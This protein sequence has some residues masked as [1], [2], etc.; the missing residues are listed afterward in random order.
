MDFYKIRTREV[1][2]DVIEI[3]PSFLV[4]QSK[5]LMVRG[6]KFYAIWDAEK[7]LWST[8]ASDVCR[9]I[10]NELWDARHKIAEENPGKKIRISTMT[11][12]SSRLWTEFLKFVR[13]AVD[14][15]HQLD[16]SLTFLSSKTKKKDYSS[17]RLSY[18]LCSGDHS[19]YDEI[20]RTLYADE[21]R[22]KI[23]W[24]IGSIIAGDSKTIQKF[25]VL[26]GEPGVGKGT[27][28]N[29]IQLL[30]EGYYA[31]FD[32][33]ALTT[34]NDS[35]STEVLK[36]N[37]LVAIQHDGDL[38]KI[39]DNTK[40]NSIIAHEHTIINEKYKGKYSMNLNGFLFIGSNKPVKITESRSGIIRRLIDVHPANRPIEPKRYQMLM[41]QV[42]FELGAIA[43]HCLNV[44]REMGKN[45]YSNYKPFAM[46]YQTDP[47]FNFV[48]DSYDLF[49]ETP[50]ISLTRAYDMYKRYCEEAGLEF[51]M[52]RP[53]MREE[54]KTY[55]SAYHDR[56]R[57]DG[58]LVRH[59]FEGF[60]TNKFQIQKEDIE[61][62][63]ISLTLDYSVSLLDEAFSDCPAQYCTEDE[64]PLF[65]WCNVKTK[66][67][68]LDTRRTHYVLP[69]GIHICI[70]F[71]IR[72]EK[73]EK[74]PILNLEAASKWPSTYAEYSKSGGGI[75]LH[76]IYEGDVGKLSRL[77]QEGI[78]VK[79]FTG[80][81]S[82]RRKLS[83]CNNVPIA[84]LTG[85][86]PLKGEK[87]VNL[88]QIKSEKGLREMILRNLRK[89]I[90]QATKPSMDFIDKILNDAYVSGMKYDVSD[91][92][93]KILVFATG[94]TNQSDYCIKLIKNMK[95]KSEE[96]EV[97]APIEETTELV[98][99]DVEVFP[100][101]FIVN[102]KIDGEEKKVVRMINPTPS[103]IEELMKMKLVG[104]NCRRYDN[105]ILYGR[106]LGYNNLQL[107]QL[108]KR[109]IDGVPGSLFGEAYNISYT[110]VLDF[111]S[112]KQSL[113][114]F[115][116]EL[117]IHHQ[118]LGLPWD[119]PVP[120]EKW[121]LVAEYCDNDVIATEA[122]F[123][124]RS[125]DWAGRLILAELAGMTPNDTTNTL[126]TRI[127]FGKERNPQS[128][129]NYRFM[130]DMENGS[131][132]SI[133]D[134]TDPNFT[135]FD[136]TKPIFPGYTFDSGKSTYRG[137]E[138][139]EGGYVYATPGMHF[140]VSV[141]DIASMHPSSIVAENLFGDKYTRRFQDILEARLAIKHGEYDVAR[142]MFEGKLSPYL[143]D[144]ARASGLSKALKIAINSVYG[145]TSA[146][147][148][149]PFRDIRNIDNIVA[150][151]GA[152][153]MINLKHEVQARGFKMYV[154]SPYTV[155]DPVAHIK[156]DSIK[157]PHAT[158]EIIKF[159]EDY[160]KAYGYTFELEDV[161][162]RM[163]L[164]NDAVFICK[165]KGGKKD[166]Q[167]S[168]TGT[169]FSKPYVFKTLFS[170]EPITFL[171]KCEQKSVTTALYL[172][173]NE[174]LGEEHDYRFVGKTGLFCPIKP[175]CGGGLLVREKDGK[176]HAASGA[177]GY[178]WLE[179]EMVVALG[180][181]SDIDLGF[182]TALVDKA[183]EDISKY[184]DFDMF[185][186]S[187]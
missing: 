148:D 187:N 12:Y 50:M 101:L 126:T 98:F 167:W 26:Y 70:D 73:G 38:S 95:F 54:L 9:L 133:I 24:A 149:N 145:L 74:D 111:S 67:R 130:G 44:Y 108:S 134:G 13:E 43:Q 118:E 159:V 22:A 25:M 61:E 141:L 86:L 47:F 115:E 2:D 51:K 53:R 121:I 182:H 129:F 105:H 88:D 35:F 94:S 40:L 64:T 132:Y 125:D 102:W 76:Y 107:Y 80:N 28:L 36:D 180:K 162:D 48:E 174:D 56:T 75:H 84:I 1:K 128:Q 10:D 114:K 49:S 171:D 20:I 4:G 21:E 169:Q 57:V 153:F 31:S 7:N 140:N 157:I 58:V 160:G 82:L 116:I 158:P 103:E 17:K 147:F 71:D 96:V 33:K 100:N 175:G 8:N 168:A 23:E 124:D 172:D 109:I 83:K 6:Q 151:R 78:E 34:S 136:G 81:S 112:V 184:G 5:D 99:F 123:H 14:D 52:N 32:A 46:M 106:Y 177:K 97:K 155:Q 87:M 66:L 165:Y 138:V 3:Y 89:E 62:A 93:S 72:N 79:V 113:K 30:F 144:K 18:D 90:H 91:M 42:E 27:I 173:M 63:P 154:G 55:F 185:V 60:L 150:K 122:V 152:L 92:R 19:S 45:F 183:I 166:G 39:E 163:C 164:V 179:A 176:Y 146:K 127:I 135:I 68:D 186:S 15:Y 77:Y 16:E 181:E 69:P 11:D 156:T 161:Y 85:G 143:D 178:R 117:G 142:K 104:F 110:D 131:T 29:I 37:P 139:G 119:E 120:E 137:E 41:S 59:V 65:K 170:K